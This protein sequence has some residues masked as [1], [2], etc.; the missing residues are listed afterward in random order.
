MDE[1]YTQIQTKIN[2]LCNSTTMSTMTFQSK[3]N[4][5]KSSDINLSKALSQILRHQ[6]V[7]LKLDMDLEGYVKVD[8]ILA[9]DLN[10]IRGCTL[11][12][13]ER[14]VKN[15][16]G[17]VDKQ[18]FDL[19]QKEKTWY[20][21][22]RQGHSSSVGELLDD[23]KMLTVIEK[24]LATCIHGTTKDNYTKILESGGLSCMNRTHI[25]FAQEA[26]SNA[27]IRHNAQTLIY[28]DMEKAMK[29]GIVFYLSDN[30]VILTKG[31]NGILSSD[32]FIP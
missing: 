8:D 20:I 27:G 9:K 31:N 16:G 22:A 26:T 12:D 18:R 2:A 7:E 21:R 19:K 24:P 5:N 11:K 1:Q 14:V 13:I 3:R 23:E 10:R 15:N 6:I 25:H 29:D 32:Y 4:C 30:G 17:K 28:I